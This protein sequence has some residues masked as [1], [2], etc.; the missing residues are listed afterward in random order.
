MKSVDNHPELDT[1]VINCTIMNSVTV[2]YRLT[3]RDE[4]NCYSELA[5]DFIINTP[6]EFNFDLCLGFLQRSPRELLHRWD[7]GSIRKLLQIGGRPVL[8]ELNNAIHDTATADQRGIRVRV[9]NTMLNEAERSL[10][11]HYVRAWFDLD[12]DLRPFYEKVT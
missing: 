10:L 7:N 6:S 4:Q 8:F 1:F 5:M 12:T 9:L 2:Q 11:E 3:H